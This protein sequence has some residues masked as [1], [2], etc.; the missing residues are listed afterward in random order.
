MPRFINWRFALAALSIVYCAVMWRTAWIADDAMIT[1]RSVQNFIHGYGP[2]F[3][4]NERVQ[5]FTH[6][7][8]FF[9]TTAATL[10]TGGPYSGIISSGFLINL[11]TLGVLARQFGKSAI[12]LLCAMLLSKAFVD[13]AN[14]GLEN[15]LTFLLLAL[16]IPLAATDDTPRKWM[17]AGLYCGLLI[18]TRPDLGLMLAAMTAAFFRRPGF[19]WVAIGLLPLIAWEAFSLFYYGSLIPNTALAKL[20]T[21]L[22]RI[23]LVIQGFVYL[24]YSAVFDPLTILII[25]FFL[26]L[27]FR[28]KSLRFVAGFVLA[29][30]AYTVWIGGDF[31]AGRFF[32]PPF[33][34]S[35]IG[36]ALLLR[37][38][39]LQQIW[40]RRAA[41]VLVLAGL[42][43][44]YL[45]L[46]YVAYGIHIGSDFAGGSFFV[47]P[48]LTS[49]AG[50]ALLMRERPL[51]RLWTRRAVH[52]TILAG[53]PAVC[54]MLTVGGS[55]DIHMIKGIEDERSHYF[56]RGYGLADGALSAGFPKLPE[57]RV[58]KAYPQ[59]VNVVCGRLGTL[60]LRAGP[61]AHYV[62][63]CGLADPLLARLPAQDGKRMNWRIGH[64]KRSVPEGYVESI[65]GGDAAIAHSVVA[66]LHEDLRIALS[67]PLPNPDRFGAIWRLH[68]KDYG[69]ASM[70]TAAAASPAAG[71]N[72]LAA[73]SWFGMEFW[74]RAEEEDVERC[75]IWRLHTKE[76]GIASTRTAAAASPATGQNALAACSW[77]RMEFWKRAEEE[78][79]ERCVG[80]GARIDAQDN[81]YGATPLHWAAEHGTMGAVRA[82]IDAGAYID[83]KDDRGRRPLHRAAA[84][85]TADA[86]QSL[87][88][89]GAAVD[90]R[91]YQNRTPLHA[92]AHFGKPE[93]AR[94]LINAGA[95]IEA[96]TRVGSTPLHE[97][98]EDGTAESVRALVDAGANVKARNLFGRYPADLAKRND[99]VRND[100]VYLLLSNGRR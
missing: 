47:P 82:L 53:V 46:A 72:P 17:L 74:K 50:I 41:W 38:R 42:P 21:G 75:A 64:V 16:L 86:V 52:G 25:A 67:T 89:A 81:K 51:P 70:R 90:A 93:A 44:I 54:L 99:A 100:P 96:R 56:S 33:F 43:A 45:N 3:H 58:E 2:V 37:K 48:L 76:H 95:D 97:A 55:Y 87:I 65:E 13:F 39:S 83:A 10:A 12:Y 98:T 18:L 22:P 4:V 26:C 7:S 30:I 91:T 23:E 34:A 80:R 63:E 94:L 32:T 88:N 19:A 84:H 79:V 29:Y 9:L 60:S 5:S 35:L 57:W 69:I 1:L 68:T 85:G 28:R 77:F 14:S 36:L 31:M 6:A 27:S 20:N 11:A 8:W 78:D 73:C 66:D 49:I 92:A 61:N 24:I 71:Q 15:P 40:E 62:D 59:E